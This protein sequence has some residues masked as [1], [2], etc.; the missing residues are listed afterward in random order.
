MGG[1]FIGQNGSDGLEYNFSQL[2]EQDL[3]M[4]RRP[5]PVFTNNPAER[6]SSVLGPGFIN[7]CPCCKCEVGS[8]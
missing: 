2:A 4:I 5:Q 3:E 1:I 8:V 7:P 6:N